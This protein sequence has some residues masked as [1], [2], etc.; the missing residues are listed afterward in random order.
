MVEIIATIISVALTFGA[1]LLV[2]LGALTLAGATIDFYS[3]SITILTTM[4]TGYF[5]VALL[6]AV[7]SK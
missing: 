3:V 5:I 4:I 6:K 7:H 2:A 1:Y